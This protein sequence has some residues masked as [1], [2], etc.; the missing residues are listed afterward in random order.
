VL[1]WPGDKGVDMEA[2]IHRFGLRTSF[3]EPVLAAARATAE[4]IEAAEIARRKDW[5]DKLVITIDPADART[6]TTRFG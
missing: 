3:S 2:V 5:R 6:T 1:G 4:T